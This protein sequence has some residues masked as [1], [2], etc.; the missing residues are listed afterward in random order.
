[1]VL[2]VYDRID[3]ATRGWMTLDEDGNV[4]RTEAGRARSHELGLKFEA[5][6]L[7]RPDLT[8]E[9]L[10]LLRM[11]GEQIRANAGAFESFEAHRFVEPP[12]SFS[13]GIDRAIRAFGGMDELEAVLDE[14]NRAVFAKESVEVGV[15]EDARPSAN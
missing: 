8:P 14:L 12:F 1:L 5:W 10:R 6:L 9:Q 13:G 3:P 11:V 7:S 2:D 15:S 4:V